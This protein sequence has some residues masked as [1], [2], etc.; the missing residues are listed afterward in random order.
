MRAPPRA[1][2]A[3]RGRVNCSSRVLEARRQT[4]QLLVQSTQ[5]RRPPPRS[6][7]RGREGKRHHRQIARARVGH[8]VPSPRVSDDNTIRMVADA[9]FR[10]KGHPSPDRA[11]EQRRHARLIIGTANGRSGSRERPGSARF[12]SARLPDGLLDKSVRNL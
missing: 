3:G 6:V 5:L 2:R 10:G 8:D 4:G 12:G 11:C 7:L 9:A 1:R